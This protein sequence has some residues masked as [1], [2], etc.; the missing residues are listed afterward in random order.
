MVQLETAGKKIDTIDVT[1]SYKIIELFSAGLYSSPNKAFEELVSNSYDA[2]ASRVSVYVPS[3]LTVDSAYIWVCDNGESMNQ[4]GLKELWKIGESSKRTPAREKKRLQ[5]G[6]FGIGK[7]ATYVLANKLTYI[8]KKEGK[9]LAVTMDYQNINDSNEQLLLDERELTE[10]QANELLEQYVTQNG[11]DIVK[12]KL[13]GKGSEPNWTF[14]I[15]TSLKTKAHEISEGRLKWVLRTAL[16]LNPSFKLNYNGADV[17]S[18]KIDMP[19]A[20]EW[21]LGKDDKT[22]ESDSGISVSEKKGQ[23][24]LDFENLK[25][26]H[27]KIELYVDSLVTGKS[28]D[29]GRSH[30]IFLMVRGRLINL[31]EPLLGLEAFS[32]GVFNRSQI[33]IYADELDSNLASTREAIKESKP[34]TQLKS[35]LKKKFNNE[36]RKF[37]FDEENK[38]SESQ[39]ISYRLSQTSLTASKRPL[40]VFAE[41]YFNNEIA[42]PLLIKKP[43]KST[44]DSLLKELRTELSDE[45]SIIKETSWEI[46]DSS[47]PIAKLDLATGIVSINLIHP[48]IANYFSELSKKLPL[49]FVAITEVL[50]EAHLYELGV[51]E[52][53]INSVI[54]RRDSTLREL[55]LS[56]KEGTPAVAQMLKD[57][58]T[59]SLGLEEALTRSFIALG[60]EATSIGKKG[61]PDGLATAVLGYNTSGVNEGYRLTYEAKST[62]KKKIMASTANLATVNKHKTDYTADFAV[63]VAVDFDGSADSDSSISKTCKQQKITAIKSSDLIRILLLSAPKQI[64]LK[65]FR[66][67]LESCH[68]PLEV[69]EWVD[70]I[71]N[72]QVDYGPVKELLE[73][74]YELQSSDT[75]PPELASVRLKLNQKLEDGEGLSK[76]KIKDILASLNTFVPGFISIEGDVVGIQGQPEKVM[77]VISNQISSSVPNELQ[78]IYFDAFSA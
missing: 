67:L 33:T 72:E 65:R 24:F 4:N 57:S 48:Y 54:R 31:D 66:E 75:E 56:D 5:I 17:T 27:G 28:S 47:D 45:Q 73:T 70:N 23:H 69:S 46:M 77:A 22:A 35:Y 63:V 41:K 8:C 7:L 25:G 30:G 15:L 51:D 53:I 18:S 49:E 71:A 38:N 21:I 42:N 9:F 11:I 50:T 64:G 10:A 43:D 62:G 34:L 26:V 29:L 58:V 44:K 32:H 61:N 74:I 12:F 39:K 2:F 78:Q 6:R 60:F 40:L 37:Y 59:H 36:V 55:S 19:L 52:E 13:F 1:L 76:E 16:P 14:S 20:R 3:D 68:T